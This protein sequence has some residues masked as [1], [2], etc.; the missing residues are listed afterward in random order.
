MPKIVGH[1][2]NPSKFADPA[3]LLH[4]GEAAL[5]LNPLNWDLPVLA[6][7]VAGGEVY[8]A[9]ER[10]PGADG[11]RLVEEYLSTAD[12][13]AL[14]PTPDDKSWP[15]DNLASG[16][17]SPT[18]SAA[19]RGVYKAAKAA[20]AARHDAFEQSGDPNYLQPFLVYFVD[21]RGAILL[22]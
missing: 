13:K 6:F 2:P 19:E 7:V 4:G 22:G 16:V 10:A 21:D 20:T 8:F 14:E 1:T 5:L 17:I 18:G 9:W 3:D 15:Y 11:K 12:P